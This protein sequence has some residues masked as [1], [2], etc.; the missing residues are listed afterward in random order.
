MENI[1]GSRNSLWR[2]V[3]IGSADDNGFVVFAGVDFTLGGFLVSCL[4]S[5]KSFKTDAISTGCV[6]S[7]VPLLCLSILIPR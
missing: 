3:R 7:M 4:S 6:H 2:E 1:D 5:P